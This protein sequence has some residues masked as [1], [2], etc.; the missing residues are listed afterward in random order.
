MLPIENDLGLIAGTSSN[1][2]SKLFIFLVVLGKSRKTSIIVRL[3]LELKYQ[4]S[5]F[6]KIYIVNQGVSL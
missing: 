1:K 2:I 4:I 3:G 6:I 5:P